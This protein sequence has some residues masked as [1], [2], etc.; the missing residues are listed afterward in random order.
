MGQDTKIPSE[1]EA[2]KAALVASL[3]QVR[4]SAEFRATYQRNDGTLTE[5]PESIDAVRAMPMRNVASGIYVKLG[6]Y[7]RQRLIYAGASISEEANFPGK[8]GQTVSVIQNLSSDEM[9]GPGL[10]LRYIPRQ[11][12]NSGNASLSAIPDEAGHAGDCTGSFIE[13][14]PLNPMMGCLEHFPGDPHSRFALAD[15]AVEELDD[16]R[17]SLT[18]VRHFDGSPPYGVERSLVWRTDF[19]IPVIEQVASVV[20]YDDESRPPRRKEC[21][22]SDFRKCND[23]MI[24]SRILLLSNDAFI[25]QDGERLPRVRVREWRSSDLGDVP[26]TPDDF[27]ITLPA[28][29]MLG[30]MGGVAASGEERTIRFLDLTPED[31]GTSIMEFVPAAMASDL[32]PADNRRSWRLGVLLFGNVVVITI[33]ALLRMRSKKGDVAGGDAPSP[34]G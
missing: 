2:L 25:M 32:P 23:V 29:V 34:T 16:V 19:D 30:G 1:N 18:A 17:V 31:L 22:L 14:S 27:I 4:A 12:H 21:W 10:H 9:R 11:R 5:W 3:R 33:V 13:M 7:E 24:A 15:F 8:A 28:D 6:E 26:P 20:T